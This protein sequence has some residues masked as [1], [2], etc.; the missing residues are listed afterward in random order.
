MPC[1]IES[2]GSE[3]RFESASTLTSFKGGGSAK[4]IL[5]SGERE[6]AS[7]MGALWAEGLSPYVLGGGSD[8]VI[9]D[10]ICSRPVVCTKRMRGLRFDGEIARFEA[11]VTVA[12]LMREARARGLGGLEFLEG[13]PATLGGATRMNAGAFK[14]KM[15]DFVLYARVLS[16]DGDACGIKEEI[17]EFSYRRGARGIV[18][19]GALRLKR[20][21]ESESLR[22][23]ERFLKLRREKQPNLP[24]CG[25]VF[26]NA[27][28][29]V[30]DAADVLRA[31]RLE[32]TQTPSDKIILP[33]GRLIDACGLKGAR[34]GGATISRMHANFIVNVG[35]ATAT[36]FLKL[37]EIAR[38]AVYEKFGILLES[39]FALLR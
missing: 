39:E 9:A 15:S 18:A 10:G 4:I 37:V 38:R 12:Y 35:G 26:K 3:V 16:A 29:S 14:E 32:Q 17:P 34:E 11:G 6:F 36:D 33:A 25:S 13:V 19:G 5:P 8:A 28:L 24:S 1:D 30:K 21:S 2:M 20:M 27:E 31:L 22:R 23:R 7:V